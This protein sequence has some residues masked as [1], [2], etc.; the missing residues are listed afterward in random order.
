MIV[1]N[2]YTSAEKQLI[3]T[4]AWFRTRYALFMGLSLERKADVNN[5]EN[6]GKNWI[7]KFKEDWSEAFTSLSAKNII[8]LIDDEYA[9]TDYGKSVNDEIDSEIPFYK[10][11]YDNYFQL[12]YQSKAH[13][14]FCE[15]VYGVDLSQHG[16]IDQ[17]EL[18]FL[19]EMLKMSGAKKIVDIGCGNGKITEWISKQTET[20]CLGI[21]ISIE[22][23]M[24]AKERTKNNKLLDF[25]IGNLNNIQLS[26]EFDSV[27]FLDTL[28]YSNN[29]KDTINNSL[30]V[31]NKG[32]NIFAYFSQWI[33][34]EAYS[35][36]LNPDKTHL[37]KV[38]NEL[39]LD[40]SFVNLSESGIKH[41]KTK[42]EVLNSM[43]SN[44]IKEG[45]EN[46]WQYRHREAERYA[47]WGDKK[48]SRYLYQIKNKQQ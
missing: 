6:F 15:K 40:Y 24:K 48:Y 33:M 12:E 32:G 46:L 43:K 31:L 10:Y 8:T 36:N 47:N 23:I 3:T 28:Y 9:L 25:E 34:D 19:L 22:G 7:G 11:E 27:L 18:S 17:S 44:F 45:N 5:I 2:K 29:I 30:Q 42:L 14:L 26:K 16:L 38:L 41:W 1:S 37:A 35:E 21:D 13:S 4:L 20:Y 39:N